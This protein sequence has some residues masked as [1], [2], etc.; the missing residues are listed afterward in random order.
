MSGQWCGSTRRSTLPANWASEIR[1][2]ILHRDGYRCT[3]IANLDDGGPNTYLAT[4]YDLGQ[5]CPSTATDVDHIGDPTNHQ[6]H[7]LRSLCAWH[8]NVR[9]SQQGNSARAALR[10]QL[11][12]PPEQHPGL[13]R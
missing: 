1:P 7:N 9:S 6:P 10:A 3:W 12:M 5:R 11:Q 4:R 8:H 2:A 13:L